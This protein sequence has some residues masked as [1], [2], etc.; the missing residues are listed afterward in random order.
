MGKYISDINYKL[1]KATTNLRQI[2]K[3]AASR[4]TQYLAEEHQL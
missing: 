3:S 4:R 2:F 1:K